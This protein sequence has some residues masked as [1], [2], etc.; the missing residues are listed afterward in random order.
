MNV[1][2]LF[3]IAKTLAIGAAD[4]V[5]KQAKKTCNLIKGHAAVLSLVCAGG[6]ISEAAKILDVAPIT[7]A[8][9]IIGFQ[10]DR[11][12]S[13]GN[14]RQ[15]PG[16]KKR[17]TDDEQRE[18]GE[19][20]IYC[21]PV[22]IGFLTLYWTADIICNVIKIVFEKE[23]SRSTVK[24]ILAALKISYHKAEPRNIRRDDELID[25][26]MNILAPELLASDIGEEYS[27]MFLDESN[28]TANEVRKRTW[29]LKGKRLSI[30]QG[31]R[32]SLNVIGSIGIFGE[33]FF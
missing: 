6:N 19:F 8:R 3:K 5:M 20:T 29:G 10:Q 18:I 21:R 13:I 9:R 22:E 12:S 31:D 26:W 32:H 25:R 4:F 11:A 1:I 23:V 16:P 2:N 14:F 24:R 33:S 17:L 15:T 7:V 27:P 28:F 30:P